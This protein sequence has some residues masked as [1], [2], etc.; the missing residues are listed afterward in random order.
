MEFL[1][2]NLTQMASQARQMRLHSLIEQNMEFDLKLYFRVALLA[3]LLSLASGRIA[4]LNLEPCRRTGV[5]TRRKTLVARMR[6][7]NKLNPH[8]RLGLGIEPGPHWWEASALNTAPSLRLPCVLLKIL[9]E[10]YY[11]N[12]ML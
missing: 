7:N 5:L 2:L 10:Y 12:N 6:T 8:M 9:E 4:L 3:F 11:S 1:R